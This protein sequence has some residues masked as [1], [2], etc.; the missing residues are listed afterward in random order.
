MIVVPADYDN[1]YAGNPHLG[2][3]APHG[4]VRVMSAG[5]Q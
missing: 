1:A 5:R 4:E 3:L 2:R